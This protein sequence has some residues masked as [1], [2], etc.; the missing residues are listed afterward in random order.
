MILLIG[1][2]TKNGIL[3]TE[4]ANQLRERGMSVREAVTEASVMRL[5]PILMT[6]IATIGGAIPL[7]ISTGAGA[8]ARA[9][10]GSVIVGGVGL[11]TLLTTLV[12]PCIYLLLAGFSKPSNHV[13]DML[14]RMRERYGEG[15]REGEAVRPAQ[16]VQPAE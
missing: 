1:L 4:F 7:A 12:V 15:R 11:S 14:D 6:S 13:S 2:M 9:A 3:I 8:E 10:I 5:R 16:P